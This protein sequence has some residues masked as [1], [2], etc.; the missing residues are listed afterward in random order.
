M[1]AS[2][3]ICNTN[4]KRG[5]VDGGQRWHVHWRGRLTPGSWSSDNFG[6]SGRSTYESLNLV[7]WNLVSQKGCPYISLQALT[8]CTNPT[9]CPAIF[10]PVTTLIWE[11]FDNARNIVLVAL[12]RSDTCWRIAQFLGLWVTLFTER[13]K[14]WR[15]LCFCIFCDELIVCLCHIS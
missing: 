13:Q 9:F 11:G 2:G 3:H 14:A 4:M 8:Y 15:P 10:F 6:P 12:C 7:F 5:D 1:G